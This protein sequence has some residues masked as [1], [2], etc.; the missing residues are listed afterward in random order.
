VEGEF[1]LVGSKFENL[2]IAGHP[3]HV[4]VDFKLFEKFNTFDKA[5]KS[6]DA[7][8]EFR[9]IAS[10]PLGTGVELKKQG[11]HGVFLCSCVKKISVDY[12]GVTTRGHSFHV[13]GFGTIFLGEVL[14][15]HAER[16]LTMIRLELGSAI[17]GKGSGAQV[18][19][20]GRTY[21]PPP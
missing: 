11:D 9:T 10:D 6:F 12:P 21:P 16:T 8:T 7:G 3:V 1:T 15:K 20:N 13:K 14:I 4:E 5:K 19:S 2:R 17:S 18:F